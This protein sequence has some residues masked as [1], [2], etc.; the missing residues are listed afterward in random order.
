MNMKLMIAGAASAAAVLAV[1]AY[2]QVQVGN[3]SSMPGMDQ[4]MPASVDASPSTKA[5]EWRWRQ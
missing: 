4:T 2:T 3:M 1:I 5:Y